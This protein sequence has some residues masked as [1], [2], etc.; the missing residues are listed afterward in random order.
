MCHLLG[1]IFTVLTSTPTLPL[2]LNFPSHGHFS[3]TYSFYF[4]ICQSPLGRSEL[5]ES[6]AFVCSLLCP[7]DWDMFA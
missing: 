4:L 3:Q 7:R 1:D 2:P 5:C 6:K